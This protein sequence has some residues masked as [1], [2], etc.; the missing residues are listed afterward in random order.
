MQLKLSSFLA[1][2]TLA[3]A[4]LVDSANAETVSVK[5]RGPVDLKPFC[6]HG[7]SAQQLH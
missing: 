7:H 1:I 5:Y 4:L 3:L 2:S 6:M